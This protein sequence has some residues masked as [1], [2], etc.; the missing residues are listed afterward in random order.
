MPNARVL[1]LSSSA[2]HG[3]V[4]AAHA[5]AGAMRRRHPTVD[6]SELDALTKIAGWYGRAYRRV[7]L[8]LADKAPLAW[9]A[10]YTMTDKGGSPAGH[11]LTMA[12][13][14]SLIR[15][16]L[17]WQPHVILSTHFMGPEILGRV[18]RQGKLLSKL[19]LVITDHDVHRMWYSPDVRR[20]Y[21]ASELVKARL[22]LRYGVPE[23][24]IHV[25]GIPVRREFTEKQDLPAIRADLGLDPARPVV[26]FMSSGFT[27]GPIRKSI[28]GIW[29]ERPDAQIVAVCGRNQRLRRMV[30]A[31]PRPAGGVLR[32]LG[33][34]DTPWAAVAVADV[35]ISKSGG[36]TTAEC[37]T[38]GKPLIIS[39]CIP[40]QEERNVDALQEAGA[41]VLALTPEEVRWR[42]ARLLADSARLKAMARA[43]RAFARPSAANDIADAIAEDLVDTTP[44][45][46]HFHGAV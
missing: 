17:R 40:G 12:A 11:L 41:G 28:L 23:E 5:V 43:A 22:S 39:A 10:L 29:Q 6:V 15:A 4:M 33:F 14:Q 31:L 42:T 19:D 37:T 21:V 18:V 46:P 9:R 20:Y 3:H 1:V 30:D 16:C 26:L 24:R 7:Y 25:T 8:G 13:G 35:V 2:G 36:I 44:H 45:G 38:M 34:T 27:S 32:A